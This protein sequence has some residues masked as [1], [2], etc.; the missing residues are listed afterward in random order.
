MH[1]YTIVEEEEFR[2]LIQ[3]INTDVCLLRADSLHDEC[4]NLYL[5]HKD[6]LKK[7]AFRDIIHVI[8]HL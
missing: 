5:I 1:P 4:Q 6:L 8:V 7:G 2:N 3:E